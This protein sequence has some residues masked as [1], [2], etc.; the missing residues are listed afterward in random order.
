MK[1]Y[2]R[3][4]ESYIPDIDEYILEDG[5]ESYL[6]RISRMIKDST[7]KQVKFRM[8]D[9]VP[10]NGDDYEYTYKLKFQDNFGNEYE[11]YISFICTN[12]DDSWSWDNDVYDRSDW[13]REDANE[14]I[15]E[16]NK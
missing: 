11:S 12:Y 8:V 4:S 13:L 1:R 10:D 3:S 7:G 9:I 16:M 15:D 14:I 6:K 2:I 5:A